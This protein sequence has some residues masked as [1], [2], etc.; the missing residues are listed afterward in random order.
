L[1]NPTFRQ[2]FEAAFR[3]AGSDYRPDAK[4]VSPEARFDHRDFVLD[5]L[6]H[7]RWFSRDQHEEA[8]ERHG[9]KPGKQ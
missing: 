3:L 6:V 2:Q 9:C 5:A 8:A 7:H 1:P 4:L